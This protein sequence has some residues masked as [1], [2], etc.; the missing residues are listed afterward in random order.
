MIKHLLILP[1]ISKQAYRKAFQADLLEDFP[2]IKDWMNQGWLEEHDSGHNYIGLTPEGLG[3]SDYIGPQL[4][5]EEIMKKM[6]EW[7]QENA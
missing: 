6:K 4:V 3:L 5:S 2:I 7:E 1:G